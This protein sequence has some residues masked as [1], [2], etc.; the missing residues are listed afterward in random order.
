MI[1]V[2]DEPFAR[3]SGGNRYTIGSELRRG[4]IIVDITRDTV[5]TED[6]RG[7]RATYPIGSRL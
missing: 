7:N 5:I 1:V 3:D 6:G 4:E 2:D